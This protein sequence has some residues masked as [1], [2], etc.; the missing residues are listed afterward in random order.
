MTYWRQAGLNYVRYSSIAARVLRQA[1]K[2]EFR[3]EAARREESHIR[4]T[5]W[6]DGKPIN[7]IRRPPQ[8]CQNIKHSW[9]CWS[10]LPEKHCNDETHVENC[11]KTKNGDSAHNFDEFSVA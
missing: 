5:A 1:L 2:P 4:F 10:W 3:M 7:S 6:K 11:T 8:S 9:L